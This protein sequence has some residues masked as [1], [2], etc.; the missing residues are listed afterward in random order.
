MS[1]KGLGFKGAWLYGRMLYSLK[2]GFLGIL[3]L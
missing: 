1:I 3:L 2:M